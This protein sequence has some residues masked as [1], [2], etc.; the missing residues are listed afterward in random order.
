ML[1]SNDH[2]TRSEHSW[3][4]VGEYHNLM[5]VGDEL[6]TRSE[7]SIPRHDEEN[8]WGRKWVL[9]YPITLESQG[10]YQFWLEGK[11][12]VVSSNDEFRSNLRELVLLLCHRIDYER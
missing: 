8:V 10:G 12:P 3:F 6:G 2:E 7:S 9:E 11:F 5:T 4:N 1:M